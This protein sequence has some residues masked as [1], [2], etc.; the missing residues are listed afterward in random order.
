MYSQKLFH[1][2][3]CSSDA[4]E[5]AASVKNQDGH[6]DYQFTALLSESQESLLANSHLNIQVHA[7]ENPQVRK[8]R[9][10]SARWNP[11]ESLNRNYRDNWGVVV[12]VVVVCNTSNSACFI[13]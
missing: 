4:R 5:F 10:S 2:S 8:L 11:S 13:F 1:F 9:K 12:V 7:T 3:L 6:A